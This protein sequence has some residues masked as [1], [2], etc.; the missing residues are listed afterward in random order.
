MHPDISVIV[1]VYQVEPYLRTCLDSLI[2]QTKKEIEII[3]IDD[4]SPDQCGL[5]CDE[6]AAKDERVRVIHQENRGLSSAR[7]AGLDAAYGDWIMF[8]DS[9]DWVQPDFCETAYRLATEHDADL[10]IFSYER[11]KNGKVIP[12]KMPKEAEGLKTLRE[13]CS[14]LNTSIGDYCWNKICRSK[15]FEG[16]RFPEGYV[17]EDIGTTY[18]LILRAERIWYS[19]IKLYNYLYRSSSIVNHSTRERLADYYF[20]SKQKSEAL[21]AVPETQNIANTFLYHLYLDYCI[22]HARDLNDPFWVESEEGLM[23]CRPKLPALLSWKRK[24]LVFLFWYCRGLFDL[25]C[26]IKKRRIPPDAET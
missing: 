7:N 2:G 25:I 11:W 15:L 20:M 14:L 16:I 18:H 5:I 8:T 24:I 1:P 6:Y 22:A 10:A 3:V 13:A 4:G 9:D 26:H 12:V 17:Y 23:S 19:P 21:A